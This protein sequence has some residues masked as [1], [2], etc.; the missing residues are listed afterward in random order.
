MP[1]S[2][3]E[4][5]LGSVTGADRNGRS[6]VTA[7]SARARF[8]RLL[9]ALLRRGGAQL[10]GMFLAWFIA[11]SAAIYLLL[12]QTVPAADQ[13]AIAD[14]AAAL[15]TAFGALFA[16]LTAFGI[17]IEWGHHRDAEQTIGKEA[18]AALR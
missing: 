5:R 10:F 18:D 15:M 9:R 16:F 8:V 6:R 3:L 11:W 4:P 14:L 17:N 7:M 1:M 2:T 13:E 12:D